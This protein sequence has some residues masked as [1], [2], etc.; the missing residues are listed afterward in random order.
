MGLNLQLLYCKE[1]MNCEVERRHKKLDEQQVAIEKYFELWQEARDFP[2]AIEEWHFSFLDEG[3]W[4]MLSIFEEY[5]VC[6]NIN[7]KNFEDML[8][9]FAS[10][11]HNEFLCLW[12]SAESYYIENL[13]FDFKN[14]IPRDA[15]VNE[16]QNNLFQT[17]IM[18]NSYNHRFVENLRH[19][20]LIT[21][22]WLHY[23]I[24]P[25]KLNFHKDA[26]TYFIGNVCIELFGQH[27]FWSDEVV[28]EELD[29]IENMYA[30]IVLK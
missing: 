16:Q 3:A 10:L 21:V 20:S 11:S 18:A 30:K 12:H 24:C 2:C 29:R 8:K 1:I 15:E 7:P 13:K 4:N 14:G 28:A 6:N 19:M 25:S 27:S 17:W 26:T 5:R 23:T 22:L 9:W